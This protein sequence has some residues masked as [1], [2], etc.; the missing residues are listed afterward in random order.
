[1]EKS[2]DQS[3]SIYKAKIPELQQT[4]DMV[5][6]LSKKREHAEEVTVNYALCDTIFAKAKV[7]TEQGKLCLWIGAST[8]VEYTYEEAL[9]MLGTQLVQC[10]AKI[11]ELNEDLYHLRGNSITVEVN[12]ARIFNHSVKLKKLASSTPASGGEVSK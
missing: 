8:M 9:E 4:I 7:Q 1:M 5:E 6:V 10:H 2:F 11:E 3:K 12:M